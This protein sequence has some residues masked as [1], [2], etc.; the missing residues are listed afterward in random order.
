M[1]EFSFKNVDITKVETKILYKLLGKLLTDKI[2]AYN[3]LI[4]Y[5]NLVLII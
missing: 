3:S 5:N 2:S 4:S 1:K